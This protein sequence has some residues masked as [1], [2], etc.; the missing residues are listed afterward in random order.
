VYLVRGTAGPAVK[1]RDLERQELQSVWSIDRAELIER[2][3]IHEPKGG[4]VLSPQRFDVQGWPSGEPELYGPMLLDCFDRG[5]AACGAFDGDL[6]IGAM[7]LE[8]RFIGRA[9]DRLQ[10]KFLHVSH[11]YRRAGLGGA[12]FEHAVERA[13][14]T[15]ARRL[16]ISATPSEN[17]VRFYLQLGCRVTDDLDAALFDVEPEDIHLE[18]EI[19]APR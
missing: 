11:R 16:Y 5:G 4:L 15:G 18:F 14:S 13:R 6:L 19:P 3:Y 12:L 7:V 10:L 1:I 17:T 9:G 2:I 8:S